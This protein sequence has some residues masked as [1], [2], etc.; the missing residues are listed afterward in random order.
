ML[1]GCCL[2]PPNR[3]GADG[4]RSLWPWRLLEAIHRAA[5]PL[6]QSIPHQALVKLDS[7]LVADVAGG[8]KLYC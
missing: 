6:E 5:G 2:H 1:L 7:E 8:F 3:Q 4:T